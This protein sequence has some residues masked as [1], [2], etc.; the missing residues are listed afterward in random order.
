M[1][2]RNKSKYKKMFFLLP[3][4]RPYKMKC[5]RC[6]LEIILL[7]IL[8]LPLPA[9]NG[10]CIDVLTKGEETNIF[11]ECLC[12]I[13]VINVI[14]VVLSVN[15]KRKVAEVGNS[16]V[17]SI[18]VELSCKTMFLPMNYVNS[19]NKGYIFSR[20][21]ECENIRTLF[22]SNIVSLLLGGI[23]FAL[24]FFAI[25]LI[26]FRLATVTFAF[27]PILFIMMNYNSKR[28]AKSTEE[29]AEHTAKNSSIIV[30]M[31]DSIKHIK[32]FDIYRLQEDK[33]LDSMKKL[34]NKKNQ[35]A[36]WIT[37]YGESIQ[38]ISGLHNLIILAFA[39]YLIYEGQISIGIYITYIGYS[40]KVF[41]NILSLT[42]FGVLLNPVLVSIKRIQEFLGLENESN[43][44]IKTDNIINRI[45]FENVFFRYIKNNENFILND[46]CCEI[47]K[48]KPTLL[49]G[50]NGTGKTTLISLILGL[51][52]IDEG[53]ITIDKVDIR[54]CEKTQ[55]R[56]S[57]SYMSQ[58]AGLFEGSLE[59][60]LIVGQKKPI[61]IKKKLQE[62]NLYTLL[63]R[64]D[65]DLQYPILH[66]G[67]N[68]SGGGQKQIVSFLRVAIQERS[69]IILD[70]PTNFLDVNTKYIFW[71]F[72]KKYYISKR[73]LILVTHDENI[74][75]D[76]EVGD[77]QIIKFV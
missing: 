66:N 58:E 74:K 67:A 26:D 5:L 18:K 43:G 46:F 68:L 51:Y 61:D 42:G 45:V 25:F 16:V 23:D 29:V 14:K 37:I 48:D 34:L 50:N 59:E 64:F 52:E 38:L 36:K 56:N 28:M 75:N 6:I 27:L 76:I 41:G 57:I 7:S 73:I 10:K 3:Y 40:S 24:S 15:A 22:S 70:E 49:V 32:I 71:E 11:I 77:M 69:V 63:E 13:F 12:L 47:T 72:I 60:N 55:L 1:G 44:I 39:G 30:N 17:N 4:L 2:L 33:I 62:L 35:Q 20:I 31:I 65:F 8:T 53:N 21:S 19:T 9:L 54:E